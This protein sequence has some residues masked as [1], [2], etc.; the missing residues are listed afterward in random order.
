MA[1]CALFS[2]A[3]LFGSGRLSVGYASDYVRRGAMLSEEALQ[4]RASYLSEAGPLLL[5]G[6]IGVNQPTGD[7]EDSYLISGG[8]AAEI[9]NLLTV[10][11]GLEHFETLD[12]ASAL[13]VVV[14]V[15]VDSVLNP[16]LYV[17]RNTDDDLYTF[18]VSLGHTIPLK[19]INL[20]LGALYGFTDV[21]ET[22]DEDYWVLSA[23][24]S[25]ALSDSADVRFT[26]DYV[27]SDLSAEN[28]VF[29]AALGV[30]F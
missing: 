2:N 8:A 9:A 29:G 15:N 27:D 23:A 13:D 4:S 7:G 26:Y 25:V 22:V 1:L 24:T 20:E 14:D 5:G 6:S 10:Y 28:N 18:E 16:S 17:A 11:V 30:S 21:T 12:Q 19:A 3:F